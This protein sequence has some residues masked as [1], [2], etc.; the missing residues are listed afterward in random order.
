MMMEAAELNVP[1]SLPHLAVARLAG[2]DGAIPL[3]RYTGKIQYCYV[4]SCVFCFLNDETYFSRL[5][6]MNFFHCMNDT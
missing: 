6:G 1:A 4:V 3:V 5:D 2:H